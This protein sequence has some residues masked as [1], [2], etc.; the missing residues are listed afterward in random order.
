ME[1]IPVD[2]RKILLESPMRMRDRFQFRSTCRFWWISRTGYLN[3]GSG[4]TQNVSSGGLAIVTTGVPSLGVVVLVEVDLGNTLD[5]TAEGTL[6]VAVPERVLR[7]EGR[8]VRHEQQ[9]ESKQKFGFAVAATQ[10]TIEA[11]HTRLDGPALEEHY[12]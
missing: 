5:G 1:A 11:A 4:I 10:A 12:A 6:P 9:D 2:D 8:V 7:V 3:S